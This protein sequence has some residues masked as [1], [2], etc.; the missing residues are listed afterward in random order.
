MTK[1]S[2]EFKDALVEKVIGEP[3]R[4]MRSVAKEAR[5]GIS[6][7]HKWVHDTKAKAGEAN[8]IARHVS[9]SPTSWSLAK[10]LKAIIETSSLTD[11]AINRYCRQQ[12]LYKN[13]IEQWKLEFMSE[14][15]N[16]AKE[17]AN[18]LKS[19]R[20]KNKQLQ[21]ELQRKEKALAEASA[22]LLLKKNLDQLWLVDEDNIDP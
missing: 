18:E 15:D 17:T 6:S 8:I 20:A 5:V 13:Q 7:L 11:D 3:M 21:R 22:L 16:S 19:L 12:G 2:N 9:E 1:F 4:S 10:K 14:R